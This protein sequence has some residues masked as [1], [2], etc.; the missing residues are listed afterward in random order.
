LSSSKERLE[1]PFWHYAVI[2]NLASKFNLTD[3]R[4]FLVP[5]E[6]VLDDVPGA[7]DLR[8]VGSPPSSA[9]RR[10]VERLFQM[11]GRVGI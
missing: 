6:V 11:L 4:I 1:V 7:N 8:E 2:V 10:Q 9:L 3:L 5:L